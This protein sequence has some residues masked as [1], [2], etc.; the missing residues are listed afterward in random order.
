MF[1]NIAKHW[2]MMGIKFQVIEPEP[3]LILK[4][5]RLPTLVRN[6]TSWSDVIH[7]LLFTVLFIP[8][9]LSAR[10]FSMVLSCNNHLLSLLPAV[11]LSRLRRK[12]CV[13]IVHHYD[14]IDGENLSTS[15]FGIFR[16]VR[17]MGYG[18]L[19]SLLKAFAT[20][21]AIIMAKSCEG[22]IC[23][24]KVFTKIFPNSYLSSNGVDHDLIDSIRGGKK[25]YEACFVGRLD[26]KKGILDLLEVWKIVVTNLPSAKLTL[27]GHDQIGIGRFIRNY[28]LGDNVIYL[29]VLSDKRMYEIVK[30][31]RVFVTMSTAEGWGI[32]IAEAL[33]CGTPVV[34]RKIKTL[35]EQWKT[36]PYVFFT[37]P[38]NNQDAAEKIIKILKLRNVIPLKIKKCIENLS[39][40]DVALTDAKIIR[41]II[42]KD[43]SMENAL[44]Y[45]P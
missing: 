1:I 42:K 13:V 44:A 40:K 6:N 21:M 2:D 24:S 33:A 4:S 7:G 26:I 34:C 11:L 8:V 29:G 23:V 38:N 5:S 14:I 18:C 30:K 25:E 22:T 19:Y 16:I 12:P 27:I 45:K 28:G 31:S 20:K 32:A 43:K 36:C 39:W 35:Y 37:K 41:K 9:A 15:L 10:G 17:G 3:G